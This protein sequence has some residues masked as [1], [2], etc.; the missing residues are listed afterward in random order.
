MYVVFTAFVGRET[1]YYQKSPIF[2]GAIISISPTVFTCIDGDSSSNARKS[3]MAVFPGLKTLILGEVSDIM[4]V[5][6]LK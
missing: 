1:M 5:R 4:S 2:T 3:W 6:K